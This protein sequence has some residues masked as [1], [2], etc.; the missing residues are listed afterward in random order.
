MLFRSLNVIELLGQLFYILAQL[1]LGNLGV[2]LLGHKDIKTTQV[3]AK[4]TKE[5]LS[6]DVEKLSQ[7]LHRR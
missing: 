2:H 4:I 7:Q 5:K 6:K 3:Y 1:F